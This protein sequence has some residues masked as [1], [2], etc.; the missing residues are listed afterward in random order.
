MSWIRFKKIHNFL[1]NHSMGSWSPSE[2][3][4]NFQGMKC[5]VL[6]PCSHKRKDESYFMKAS[7][8]DHAKCLS[9]VLA[10]FPYFIILMG[11]RWSEA[12]PRLCER[13]MT[14]P[15]L[16]KFGS[17][18]GANSQMVSDFTR[19]GRCFSSFQVPHFPKHV[20]SGLT[21]GSEPG[22]EVPGRPYSLCG[23]C[24]VPQLC[25]P[26][27]LPPLRAPSK[28]NSVVRNNGLIYMGGQK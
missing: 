12:M 10:C 7:V 28:G 1:K 4:K 20:Y 23:L 24:K 17:E 25:Q 26:P 14:I 21:C 15:G 8:S 13:A 16:P 6:G 27:C 5:G 18:S 9:P 11:S 3:P 19:S 2:K 22:T